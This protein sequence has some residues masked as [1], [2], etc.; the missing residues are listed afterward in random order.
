MHLQHILQP[1]GAEH[2]FSKS[3]VREGTMLWLPADQGLP[4][5]HLGGFIKAAA[6]YAYV[7]V[8]PPNGE[9]QGL[10][11]SQGVSHGADCRI[12]GCM[13]R[14]RVYTLSQPVL[15]SPP[16]SAVQCLRGITC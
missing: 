6:P 5:H 12:L 2:F 8:Q 15:Q 10:T 13:F 11:P 9:S 14:C 7:I 16:R 4:K 3:L 1:N